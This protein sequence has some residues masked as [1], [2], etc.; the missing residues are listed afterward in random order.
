MFIVEG[1]ENARP[2]IL[3]GGTSINAGYYSRGEAKFNKE[4]KLMDDDLIEDSYQWVEEVMVFEPNVWEWQSAFQ[5]GLLEVGVTPDNG[6]IYDHVVGTKVGGT[7]FDQFGIR[8]TSA[9]FL[10]YANAESLSVFVHA[11]AHKI[12]FK[13]KGTSKS[14]AYGVEFEDSLGEMHRAFLKGGDHDEIILSAGALGSHN[15]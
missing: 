10:Q 1:V 13:T 14:T 3:G 6:F 2:R 5:A 9:Y 12:L 4:A 8:H 11:I 15:F 7:I